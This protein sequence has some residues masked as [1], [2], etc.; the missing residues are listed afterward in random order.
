MRAGLYGVSAYPTTVWNG[1]HNQVGGASGGNWESVYP[2]YLELYHEHYDL[3]S[4]FRL[5]I[6]G[7]YEPGDNE[8]NFSVEI[9]IDNDIDT[10]VNIEN[11]YV[12]V[13]AVEDNIYS[14]WGSV[15]QWH[16]A[17]NVARRYVTKSEANKNPVSVSEAGQSEIFEHNLL[18]S[19]AWEHS[20]MKIVA[21]VQKFQGEGSDHPITQAQTRNINDL[22]PDPD[23]D[24]LTYLYD[25]CHYVYNPGQEDADGDEYG[26]ACDA[27]NGLVN[28]QGNVDLDAHG[29]NFTPIIGVADVLA[30]S[31]ILDGSGLPPNDCQS[32]DML[33]DGTINN[34]DLIVLVDVIMAGG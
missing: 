8:V 24:E 1:V 15:G 27:C 9:L 30:L 13:F 18:L 5:G 32:I 33:E 11:T 17:R 10:T 31:D 22:D 19:D 16:N 14:F 7:E 34:F 23:G 29:E 12:E 26:D 21:I 25:N 4:P 3:A 20:N 2:G 6:S 28:I